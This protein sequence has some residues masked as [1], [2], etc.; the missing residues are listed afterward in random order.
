MALGQELEGHLVRRRVQ[1][2][3]RCAAMGR[4][5]CCKRCGQDRNQRQVFPEAVKRQVMKKISCQDDADASVDFSICHGNQEYTRG[6]L[7]ILLQNKH[8]FNERVWCDETSRVL[9]ASVLLE[10]ECVL[11]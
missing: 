7:F 1:C 10:I 6:L 11:R 9:R 3:S 2:V 4:K 5:D 8:H